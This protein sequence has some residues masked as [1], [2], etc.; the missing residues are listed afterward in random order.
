MADVHRWAYSYVREI[1][2][3]YSNRSTALTSFWVFSNG[4]RRFCMARQMHRTTWMICSLINGIRRRFSS[5]LKPWPWINFICFKNVDL[6][7]RTEKEE[8]DRWVTDL[9][10][11]ALPT[12]EEENEMEKHFQCRPYREVR[13][14][15]RTNSVDAT[16]PALDWY[17]YWFVPLHLDTY[18]TDDLCNIPSAI[19][20]P[21]FESETKLT[22][23]SLRMLRLVTACIL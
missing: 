12:A 8:W 23:K 6:N 20:W 21:S 17:V 18:H 22:T 5:S 11:S 14:F 4:M 15:F 7:R 10:A 19:D 16:V 3:E 13:V 9:P 1:G 2:L